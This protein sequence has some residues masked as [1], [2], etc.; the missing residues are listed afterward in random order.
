MR[1]NKINCDLKTR[2]FHCA[3]DCSLIRKKLQ[4]TFE[5]SKIKEQNKRKKDKENGCKGIAIME[6]PDSS[7]VS[8]IY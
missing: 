6:I 4:E 1:K 7:S 5:E 2:A 8:K 3:M